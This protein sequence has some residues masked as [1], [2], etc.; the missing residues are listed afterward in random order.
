MRNLRLLLCH[1]QGFRTRGS[2]ACV[3]PSVGGHRLVIVRNKGNDGTSPV[4]DGLSRVGT[5]CPV[6]RAICADVLEIEPVGWQGR[7]HAERCCGTSV[8]SEN[9]GGQKTWGD[10]RSFAGPP[11]LRCELR[12]NSKLLIRNQCSSSFTVRVDLV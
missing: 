10:C 7:Q 8:K 4:S 2:I 1:Q 11:V 9:V 12:A 5:S 3:Q 6:A